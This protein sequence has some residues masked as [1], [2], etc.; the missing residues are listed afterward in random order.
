[1]SKGPTVKPGA[2]RETRVRNE[3]KV[4]VTS[5]LIRFLAKRPIIGNK[6]VVYYVEGGTLLPRTHLH[7]S[8][9][10]FSYLWQIMI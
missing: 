2:R 5:Y 9:S 3:K 10:T 7:V 8:R 6:A 4:T 1:M